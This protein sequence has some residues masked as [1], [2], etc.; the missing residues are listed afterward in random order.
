MADFH[1]TFTPKQMFKSHTNA[2]ILACWCNLNKLLRLLK[3]ITSL[4]TKHIQWHSS[5]CI[6]LTSQHFG[7]SDKTESREY[8]KSKYSSC[9]KNSNTTQYFTEIE[10]VKI[11]A[12]N[13]TGTTI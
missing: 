9:W 7:S 13:K 1:T 4:L 11:Q 10:G 8:S 12:V 2:A 3:F 6:L 5:L